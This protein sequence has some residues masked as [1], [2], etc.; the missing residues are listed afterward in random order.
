MTLLHYLAARKQLLEMIIVH[1]G[2]KDLG[3][4]KGVVLII[5]PNQG[6]TLNWFEILQKRVWW[7]ATR[8]PHVDKARRY[9]NQEVVKFVH[10]QKG[11]VIIHQNVYLVPKLCREQ[12]YLTMEQ[13]QFWLI[14]GQELSTVWEPM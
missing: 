4:C 14:F 10:E 1:L 5:R 2:E 9:V 7:R 6:V 3:F 8:P 12:I 13:V 11:L